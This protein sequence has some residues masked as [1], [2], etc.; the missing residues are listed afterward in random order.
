ME[1][2]MFVCLLAACG[3]PDGAPA[4][5]CLTNACAAAS[6]CAM[7]TRCNQGLSPPRCEKLYCGAE[8]TTCDDSLLCASGNTCLAGVCS[9]GAKNG[10]PCDEATRIDCAAGL[11][12]VRTA[13]SCAS[14]CQPAAPQPAPGGGEC[15]LDSECASMHCQ[16]RGG[17]LGTCADPPPS[18]KPYPPGP[19]GSATGSVIAN[20]SFMG[21]S[22]PGGAA[23]YTS[24]PMAAIALADYHNDPSVTYLVLLGEAAWCVP[25]KD[26][27]SRVPGWAARYASKQVRFLEVLTEGRQ[28]VAATESDINSW[29]A[30]YQ[31]HVDVAI[32]PS[33]ALQ[34]F[35]DAASFPLALVVRTSTMTIVS[36]SVGTVDLTAT[37]DAL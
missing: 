16:N 24:L 29:A 15:A 3:S 18:P 11:F 20:L 14:T 17:C 7:G 13:G 5:D 1:R 33:A 27:Q 19:Y 8:G 22:D 9:S 25:C 35:G 31:L 36:E 32:D 23:D 21:K 28:G 37:L 4:A 34:S 2:A 6:D 12:C 30:A 26:Q 10:Q